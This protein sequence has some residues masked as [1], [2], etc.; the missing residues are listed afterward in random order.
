MG[1]EVS[2]SHIRQL[3]RGSPDLALEDTSLSLE[4]KPCLHRSLQSHQP[5]APLCWGPEGFGSE[6]SDGDK[7]VQAQPCVPP[8][9][10]PPCP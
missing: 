6:G 2:G 3:I 5:D 8:R 9:L 4:G 1:S 10:G 7:S